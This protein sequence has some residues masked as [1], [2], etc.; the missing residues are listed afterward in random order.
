M[1]RLRAATASAHRTVEAAMPALDPTL[2]RARYE[3]LLA[4]FY[5]LYAPL[6]PLY[7]AAAG[8]PATAGL[9][10]VDRA[11][12]PLLARDLAVFGHA[13]A[14]LPALPRC[15]ALPVV[16]SPSAALGVL[17]VVEGATLGGRVI[18]R[19]LRGALDLD[20]SRGAAFFHGYGTHTGAMWKRFTAHVESAPELDLEAAI[21]AA[22][23]TFTAFTHWLLAARVR[24]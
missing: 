10:L 17:Y 16:A 3:R 23:A 2:T 12:L 6:E 24:A 11:K 20:P 18:L 7:L 4:A 22:R 5:G 21:E 15:R 9:A 13:A 1:A 19:H 8:A 14:A